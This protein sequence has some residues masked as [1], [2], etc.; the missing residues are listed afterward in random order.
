MGRPH[1][2]VGFGVDDQAGPPSGTQGMAGPV[3]WSSAPEIAMQLFSRQC[4]ALKRRALV[5][6]T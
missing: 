2:R 4:I 1:A 5:K 3:P 6:I